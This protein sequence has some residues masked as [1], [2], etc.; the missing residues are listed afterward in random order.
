MAGVNVLG[1]VSKKESLILSLPE[2]PGLSVQTPLVK[3]LIGG[4]VYVKWPYLQEAE[5]RGCE[6]RRV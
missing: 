1:S 6:L 5:V 4:R 3:D 2:L